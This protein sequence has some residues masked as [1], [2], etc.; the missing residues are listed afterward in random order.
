MSDVPPEGDFFFVEDET[1]FADARRK[2]I[3]ECVQ[4]FHEGSKKVT[5]AEERLNNAL[6]DLQ[7]LEDFAREVRRLIEQRA[8]QN[9]P[10]LSRPGTRLDGY[11]HL[12]VGPWRGIF[13]VQRGGA[14]VAAIL[15]SKD[16]HAL[17]GRISEISERYQLTAPQ[18]GQS[19]A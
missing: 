11:H 17:Q 5:G 8:F 6:T 13:L 9:L 16:P 14:S 1:S 7:A 19:G 3:A 12:T 4:A 2:A 15:F 18:K 10:Q